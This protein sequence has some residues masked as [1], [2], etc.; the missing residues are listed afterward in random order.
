[1]GQNPIEGQRVHGVATDV[2]GPDGIWLCA[3]DGSRSFALKHSTAK[4]I[5]PGDRLSWIPVYR[6]GTMGAEASCIHFEDEV[7]PKPD[8]EVFDKDHDPLDDVL[9]CL[10]ALKHYDDLARYVDDRVAS[11]DMVQ[12]LADLCERAV[13]KATGEAASRLVYLAA[14]DRAQNLLAKQQ[15]AGA[16][17]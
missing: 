17:L 10:A 8:V 9:G 3:N 7:V 11:G 14:V 4:P 15:A 1:M 12:S 2:Q 6:S 16:K 5:V 13:L